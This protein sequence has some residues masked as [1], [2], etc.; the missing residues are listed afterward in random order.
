MQLSDRQIRDL[1]EVSQFTRRDKSSTVDDW[2][3]V[4][5]QKR[6]EIANRR[7]VNPGV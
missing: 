7:C 2:V 5:K 4:F 6:D 1:F 3:R